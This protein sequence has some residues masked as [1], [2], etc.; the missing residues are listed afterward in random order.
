MQGLPREQ[1]TVPRGQ[2]DIP[3]HGMDSMMGAKLDSS[4][5][6]SDYHIRQ[7]QPL[8]VGCPVAHQQRVA[9]ICEGHMQQLI[10]LDCA[11]DLSIQS[12]L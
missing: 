11:Y 1:V 3:C 10:R 9:S 4:F 12:N 6:Q 2:A 7:P 5:I 8:E